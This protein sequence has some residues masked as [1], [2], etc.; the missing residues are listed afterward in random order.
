MKGATEYTLVI[1]EEKA[2]EPA[3]VRIVEGD[4]YTETDLKPRT[5]YC[6]RVAAN[7]ANNAINQSNQINYSQP[8]CRDTDASVGS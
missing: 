2:S 5:T 6:V 3:R 1:E 7:N 4:S 8:K